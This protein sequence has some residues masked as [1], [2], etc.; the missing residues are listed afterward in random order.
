MGK[1]GGRD[2]EIVSRIS[3]TFHFGILFRLTYRKYTQAH[4]EIRETFWKITRLCELQNL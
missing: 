4:V 2:C 3:N 1:T